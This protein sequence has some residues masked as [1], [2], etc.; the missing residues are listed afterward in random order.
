LRRADYPSVE[1]QLDAA[2]QARQGD[3]AVQL[4]VDEEIRAV[5]EKYPKTDECV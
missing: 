5:K 2:Y 1:A 4:K 3:N